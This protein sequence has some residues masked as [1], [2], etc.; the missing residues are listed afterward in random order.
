MTKADAQQAYRRAWQQRC[1]AQTQ[2]GQIAAERVMDMVQGDCIDDHGPGLEWET[3]IKSIPGYCD[4][5]ERFA[6]AFGVSL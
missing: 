2:D 3:F 1:L 6:A 4:F 5:W